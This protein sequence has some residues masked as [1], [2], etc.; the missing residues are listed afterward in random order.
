[1]KLQHPSCSCSAWPWL[2][3][4]LC[5][6]KHYIFKVSFKKTNPKNVKWNFPLDS[7]DSCSAMFFLLYNVL[8]NLNIK[9]I[10]IIS[11]KLEVLLIYKSISSLFKPF[12]CLRGCLN[13][14]CESPAGHT[15]ASFHFIPTSAV[16][17]TP[18]ISSSICFPGDWSGDWQYGGL[19]GGPPLSHHCLLHPF[20]RHS[21]CILTHQHGSEGPEA[22]H[23]DLLQRL[24]VQHLLPGCRR[25]PR[26]YPEV[27]QLQRDAQGLRPWAEVALRWLRE[28]PCSPRGGWVLTARW[29]HGPKHPFHSHT[30]VKGLIWCA[31]LEVW[32]VKSNQ[33]SE[34][35]VM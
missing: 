30:V 35:R 29:V 11:Q 15:S 25:V 28:R 8:R 1:M 14:C 3:P 23:A 33:L 13:V 18:S 32:L 5:I 4:T 24:P 22:P 34:S 20:V 17:S 27:L 19:L 2:P 21:L 7:P 9:C 10:P 12:V 16:F 31:G 6:W 26:A